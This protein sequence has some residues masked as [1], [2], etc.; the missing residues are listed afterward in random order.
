LKGD[1]SMAWFAGVPREEIEW[2]PTIDPEKCLKC[3]MC[4]NCGQNVY[5]W[6]KDGPVVAQ[7]YKC[8]VG[9]TTCETLCQGEAIS[10]PDKQ[11]L[12]EFY[13]EHGIWA[14]VKKELK[15]EGK[16]EPQE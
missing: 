4:M 3:G 9:C 16:L 5:K 12:R 13:E 14:K 8:V 11:K 10:F 15:E 7:P 2:Y 1:D 6:T